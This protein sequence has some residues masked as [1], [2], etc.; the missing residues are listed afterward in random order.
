MQLYH[1][2][3]QQGVHAD[4]QIE[5]WQGPAIQASGLSYLCS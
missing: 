2:V 5:D 4:N 1:G 3:P